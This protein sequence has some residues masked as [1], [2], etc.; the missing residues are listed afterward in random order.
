[1]PRP[2]SPSE[3]TCHRL[4]R[5]WRH[6]LSGGFAGLLLCLPLL[7]C[8]DEGSP[9]AV[10]RKKLVGASNREDFA[11]GLVLYPE[12]GLLVF[13]QSGQ[14]SFPRARWGRW[15]LRLTDGIDSL[16]EQNEAQEKLRES[17]FD[18]LAL[19]DGGAVLAGSR[20]SVDAPGQAWL[21]RLDAKGET[22]WHHAF[23]AGGFF[24]QVMGLAPAPENGLLMLGSNF[25]QGQGGQM[26]GRNDLW[27][28]RLD[29]SGQEQWR[30]DKSLPDGDGQFTGLA[31]WPDGS[32]AL[33]G[34]RDP[35]GEN[36]ALWL[37]RL[38][39]DGQEMW[40]RSDYASETTFNSEGRAVA[41][42]P[43]GGLAAVGF[44]RFGAPEQPESDAWVLRLDGAGKVLWQVDS[45]LEQ[46]E[47]LATDVLAL[48][49]GGLLVG[50]VSEASGDSAGQV[51]LWRLDAKGDTLWRQDFARTPMVHEIAGLARRPDGRTLLVTSA[52]RTT[53]GADVQIVVLAPE[54]D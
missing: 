19:P 43:D 18:A 7:A 39:P 51:W 49:D 12:G 31:S 36:S 22:V 50:G 1:M 34:Y 32:A 9:P 33:V 10:E 28:R 27:L 24:V 26:R 53:K 29:G 54:E 35:A 42:L 17:V 16:W 41:V 38:A 5:L 11:N 40:E 14:G 37:L 20:W 52:H 46:V 3:P 8:S 23:P 25:H 4:S 30:H 44:R 48:P 2:P 6:V 13:G 15:V 45:E 21:T 47:D